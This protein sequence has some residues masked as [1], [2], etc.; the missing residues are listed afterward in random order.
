MPQ[1]LGLLLKPFSSLTLGF[2]RYERD[3]NAFL[4]SNFLLV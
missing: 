4:R 2:A 3:E 1:N